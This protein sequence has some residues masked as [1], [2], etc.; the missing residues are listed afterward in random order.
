MNYLPVTVYRNDGP[1]STL[2][3]VTSEYGSCLVVPCSDGHITEDDIANHDYVVLNVGE[4]GGEINFTP[5][6][7]SGWTMFGGNFVF[8]ND[9]RYSRLY[10]HRPIAVHDRQEA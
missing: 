10:G 6:G 3:G 5:A 8:S 1:D 7:L 9:S 2:G 4:K